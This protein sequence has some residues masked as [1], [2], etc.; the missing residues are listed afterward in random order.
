[1]ENFNDLP[2]EVRLSAYLDGELSQ[3]EKTDVERQ[4]AESPAA[5]QTLDRLKSGS[6][7][8]SDAFEAL[9]NQPLPPHL[10]QAVANG[11]ARVSQTDA[12]TPK[13][14]TPPQAANSNF[15]WLTRHITQAIAASAVLLLAGGYSGFLIGERKEDQPASVYLSETSGMTAAPEAKDS[16]KTRSFVLKS[17]TADRQIAFSID[18]VAKVHA[19]YSREQTRASEIPAADAVLL[20]D[21]LSK[22]AD[23][24]F[25]I[26]DL[27]GEGL[28]FDGGRLVALDGRPAAALFYRNGNHDIV[29]IYYVKGDAEPT[30]TG[31]GDVTYIA[32]EKGAVAWFVA[33]PS[34][35]NDLERVAEKARS[36][37]T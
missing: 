37:L 7:F 10:V 23:V 15:A 3:T 26:P 9:L 1:M 32:G 19:V 12:A 34:N 27:V 24:A 5:R 20:R 30:S 29:A 11:A 25:T 4:L 14:R 8:G 2:M 21:W 35:E 31:E 33:G 6:Q 22:S 16:G 13:T 28:V 18:D 17:K 36:A